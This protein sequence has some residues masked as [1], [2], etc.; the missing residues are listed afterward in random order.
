MEESAT[1]ELDM[2]LSDGT[3]DEDLPS[4]LPRQQEEEEG[5]LNGSI[6]KG[7]DPL[8]QTQRSKLQHRRA[9]INQQIN[10]EMRMRAGAENLFRATSNNKVRETVALELSFVN[11]NLQLLKEELEE[12]NSNMEVYQTDSEAVNVPMIP[13][14]LKETKDVDFTLPI[15]DFILEHYGEEASLYDGEIKELTE[16]R[17]AMRTPSRTQ[18]GLELLME[19]YNQLFYLD[20]RFFPPN[21]N[22]GVHFHWYD[23]LTGVPSCQRALAFEKG[24]VL[25]NLGSLHTQMGARQDRSCAAGVDRA[26]DAFQRAAGAFNYLKDNFSNA[27]S[28]DMSGPSLSM[29]VRLMVAQGQECVFERVTLAT[30]DATF[31]SLLRLAQEA[32]Q[33]SEVYSLAL[34]TMSQPLVKDYV[35]FSWLSTVQ[36]KAEHFSALSHYYA[37]AALCDHSPS[38]EEEEEEEEGRDQE[39]ERVFQGFYVCPPSGPL[40]S[41]VLRDPE[42][43]RKLGKAHLRRAVMRHEE[44]MRVHGLCRILRKM[45]ILQDVLSLTHRRALDKY[46]ELDCEDDFDET[47]EAPEIQPQTQQKPDITPP[48]F[49]AVHVKDLFQRL[50]PL[51][52]FSARARWSPVRQVCLQR[53]DGGLGLTLRGDSPVLVAGV[54]PG[55]CAAEAGLREGDYLVGVEGQDC[56]WSKHADVVQLLKACGHRAVCISVVTMHPAQHTQEERRSMALSQ[57]D[58]ENTRQR[59]LIGGNKGQSSASLLNWNRKKKREGGGAS[60]RLGSTFS[61][62]LGSIRDTESMY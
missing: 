39:S 45:D 61:L 56:K 44:A 6:R 24:S 40:L 35:P 31:T 3:S 27:P 18:E 62:S 16:L 36:V 55:G 10:K 5:R 60:R 37:A 20:Q 15:Q 8:S 47:S 19:Y 49:T 25:F 58:K 12:L 52:V 41:T 50:G 33:V 51:S 1:R 53:G 57:G 2:S 32:S 42:Q 46:S 14:G 11:S 9:R 22:L 43:R 23:S 17:Q 34:Q 48:D 28:L 4:T 29:L 7:C 54:L 21:R 13:L 38:C 30:W 26:I 59:L